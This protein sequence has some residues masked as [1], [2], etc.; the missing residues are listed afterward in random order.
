MWIPWLIVWIRVRAIGESGQHA[1]RGVW[2]IALAQT[3]GAH[4]NFLHLPLSPVVAIV[5]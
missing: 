5:L 2:R 4:E 1:R 3:R